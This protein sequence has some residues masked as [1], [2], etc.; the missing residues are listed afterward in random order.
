MKAMNHEW[1]VSNS[2]ILLAGLTAL[3]PMSIWASPKPYE[4]KKNME[5]H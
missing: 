5:K 4:I 1:E 3:P 2:R